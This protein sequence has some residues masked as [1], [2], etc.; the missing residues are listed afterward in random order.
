MDFRTADLELF[1]D[2][3]G[4]YMK[5]IGDLTTTLTEADE[6]YDGIRV[7]K[8][9]SGYTIVII[10]HGET[11]VPLVYRIRDLYIIGVIVGKVCYMDHKAY[12]AVNNMNELNKVIFPAKAE[13]LT[14]EFSYHFIMPKGENTEIRF[15]ELEFYLQKLTQI[16]DKMKRI[17]VMQKYLGPFV[18]LFSEAV[19]FPAIAILAQQA[20]RSD[21][22][23]I[24][25][26]ED[27][28]PPDVVL[29]EN[30]IKIHTLLLIWGRLS[31]CVKYLNDGKD[32]TATVEIKHKPTLGH[33][34]E[35]STPQEI[36]INKDTLK[37]LLGVANSYSFEKFKV[38]LPRI[39]R[40]SLNVPLPLYQ[41]QLILSNHQE[42]LLEY[43]GIT[44]QSSAAAANNVMP[45]LDMTGV[46]QLLTLGILHFT[47][48]RLH[49]TEFETVIHNSREAA[50]VATDLTDRIVRFMICSG[51][52]SEEIDY[53]N[54][55]QLQRQLTTALFRGD[56]IDGIISN[57]VAEYGIGDMD[58]Q[59][60][61]E[62]L[63]QAILDG[64]CFE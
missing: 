9:T 18:I 55:M 20:F 35:Y 45:N 44:Q 12:A 16:G 19:R 23:K 25:L 31:S 13:S 33:L 11:E 61:E 63:Y 41:Q 62:T 56:K 17:E 10:K 43:D 54:Q 52:S 24:K 32:C 38:T 1:K 5:F 6:A 8:R 37:A 51:A 21:D 26:S 34:K 59:S 2:K 22:G 36:K 60:A 39:K 30:V 27:V 42:N 53:E 47:K 7:S 28:A 50:A 58:G 29:N 48:K 49:L 14:R 40:E 46:L 15:E 4:A 57:F 3:D 64:E